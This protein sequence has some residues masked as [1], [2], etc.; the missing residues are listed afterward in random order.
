MD[1]QTKKLNLITYLVQLQDE[2]FLDKIEK[3]ILR[4]KNDTKSEE[5]KP[6]TVDELIN[7]IEKSEKNIVN[8]ETKTQDELE[9]LSTNW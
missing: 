7:R 4:K 9:K 5:F 3:F 1:I 8:N 6:F 2:N